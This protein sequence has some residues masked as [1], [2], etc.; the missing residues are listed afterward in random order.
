MAMLQFPQPKLVEK[1]GEGTWRLTG[2]VILPEDGSLD[3]AAALLGEDYPALAAA[4]KV[5]GGAVR[6]GDLVVRLGQPEVLADKTTF[7]EGFTVEVGASAELTAQS[8]RAAV[9]GLRTVFEAGELAFG[10]LAD[11]P[12]TNERGLHL[13]AG[14]KYYTKDWIMERVKDLSR[15]RMN[16]LWLHFSENEG[17][18]IDSERHPEVPSRFHL[19]KDEVREII[20]LC[21]ELFVDINPALDCP[22]HLGTAL[23][24]HPRWRLNREMAE[25]LYSA[26]DITNPDAR[27][28]LLEL[29]DEYAE[30]FAGSKVFHIGGDEFID[31]NHF[32]RFPEMDACARERLG[33]DCGGVDLYVDF[34]NQVIAHV[35]AKGFQVRVWNDGLFR[36]DQ[37]EHVELDR[38]VQIAFWSN[39]DKG[40]APLKAFLDRGYQV[41][42]YHSE[43]LYFILLIRKDYSDPDPDKILT[44]WHPGMF[45][46]HPVSGPQTLDPKSEQMLGCCYSI[47]SD[48]PDLEDEEEVD[49]RSRDSIRAFGIRCWQ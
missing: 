40:M 4:E 14:R 19:T 21:G 34:L 29:V 46:T 10:R 12:C 18:R 26:L 36:P 24:E 30:L 44:Q 33:P 13:D 47:W 38:N 15:N 9:Y 42:N 43:Y 8:R 28:F 32:E 35:R 11:W 3:R 25:P 41:V 39:W 2:R 49:R 6:P 48:W 7:D 31:F 45:P 17:F 20:A 27:A 1:T 23:L 22:G 5:R 16:V 37:A